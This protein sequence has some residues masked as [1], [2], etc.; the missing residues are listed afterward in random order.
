MTDDGISQAPPPQR[1]RTRRDERAG[2]PEFHMVEELDLC[3]EC[4]ISAWWRRKGE[5]DLRCWFCTP[6]RS[7]R[8]IEAF[9]SSADPEVPDLHGLLAELGRPATAAAL[10]RAAQDEPKVVDYVAAL[11]E[12]ATLA[13]AAG[14]QATY[15]A[16][17]A[18]MVGVMR[19]VRQRYGQGE[20]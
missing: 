3:P 20:A 13:S 8:G 19:Q 17:A 4:G 5:H 14:D 12:R 9:V 11:M 7:E 2:R 15:E 1:R 10:G 6:P 18:E 16:T